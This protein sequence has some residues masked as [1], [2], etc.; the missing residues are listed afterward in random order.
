VLIRY[1]LTIRYYPPAT[2]IN[3]IKK[4][5]EADAS[6]K[7]DYIAFM[8]NIIDK[9]YAQ[10]TVPS[11]PA[12]YVPHHGVYHLK[13]PGKLRVAFDCTCSAKCNGKSLNDQ[14]LSGPDLTNSLVAVLTRFRQEKIAV[15]ADVESMFYQVRVAECHRKFLQFVWW[16]DGDTDAEVRDYQMTLHLFG[17]TSSPSCAKFAL[18]KTAND[19]E[20][21]FGLIRVGGRLRKSSLDEGQKHPVILEFGQA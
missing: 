1:F 14:L 15:M 20:Q 13:K 4:R 18:R 11:T 10:S 2:S 17:A 21:R 19:G 3:S 16:P 7:R 12:W 6:Y 9:C 5:Y 8:N